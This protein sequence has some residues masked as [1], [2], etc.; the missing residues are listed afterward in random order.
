VAAVATLLLGTVARRDPDLRA[1][2]APDPR[3]YVGASI[4]A[5]SVLSAWRRPEAR[6]VPAHVAA[7]REA[8]LAHERSLSV[9]RARNGARLTGHV[10]ELVFESTRP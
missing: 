6:A 2:F 1:Q 3:M 8:R 10:G 4:I 9:V 5:A 7:N